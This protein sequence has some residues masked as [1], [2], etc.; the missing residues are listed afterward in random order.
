MK[1]L[2]HEWI[3]N[4]I[5]TYLYQHCTVSQKIYWVT[6]VAI[7]ITFVSLPF[8]YVDIS[9]QGGGVVRPV[10]EKTEMKSP[11]TEL[12]DSVYV[13]EGSQVKKG[14]ILLR[15]RTTNSDYK[16]TYQTNRLNDYEAHLADLVFLAKGEKPVTFQSAVRRQE[17]N[18]FAKRLCELETAMMQTEKE[19]MR[20]KALFDKKLVSEEEYDNAFYRFQGKKNELASLKEN[21]LSTWQTELNTYRNSYGE[22]NSSLKQEIK[23]KDLYVLRSPVSGTIDEFSGIYRGSNLQSGQSVA[24]ISP[25]ST[26]YFEIYVEPRNIGYLSLGM[27]VNVQVE[28]FNHNEWGTVGG[29]VKD[30]SSDFLTDAK[31]NSYYKVKCTM[32]RSFLTLRN[33]QRG[34]LK[35]GMTVSAHFM[36][37]RRSLFDL[38]YQRMDH[39]M[40]PTQYENE[41]ITINELE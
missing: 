31:G 2:P 20:E 28:S 7:T 13:H 22:M 10:A 1:L 15:F 8:V 18:Y 11:V 23:D 26:L 40:N 5:E 38:L 14:D 4:C 16:I 32:A 3:E 19:Y 6:L 39:W 41:K 9:V 25:D 17:Y 24:V 12:V 30:I 36:I 27:P 33:G 21:Q 29:K 35:K 37:T 34:Y